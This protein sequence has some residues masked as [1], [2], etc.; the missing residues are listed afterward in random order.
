MAT[1]ES[2]RSESAVRRGALWE[3]QREQ[4]LLEEEH[5]SRGLDPEATSLLGAVEAWVEGEG[6][7]SGKEGY[8]VAGSTGRQG[9]EDRVLSGLNSPRNSLDPGNNM[10]RAWFLA[11]TQLLTS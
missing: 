1:L 8:E 5:S 9:Q 4:Q 11:L 6:R 2:V 7:Q 3:E 10:W